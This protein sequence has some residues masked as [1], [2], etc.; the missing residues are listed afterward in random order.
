MAPKGKSRNEDLVQE[1]IL[2]AVVIADSFNV[3]FGPMTYKKPRTLLPLVNIPLI[4]YTFEALAASGVQEV[5]VFCCHLGDQVR[6]HV[7]QSKWLQGGSP[8]TVTTLMSD[9]CLSMG[10]ALR[11]IDAKSLIR[12]DFILITGDLVSNMDISQVVKEHKARTQGKDKSSVMT[13]VYK[14]ALPGHRTRSKEDDIFLVEEGG[15]ARLL[16]FQKSHDHRKIQIP[17]DIML[18]HDDIINHNDLMDC[19]ISVCS[20][21]VPTIFTDNFDYQTRDHFVKGILVSEEISGNKVH[22]SI[23]RDKYA[24]RVSNMHTYDA[25]SKDVINRWTYPLVP[26]LFGSTQ[27]ERIKYGRHNVYCSED[28]TLSRGCDLGQDV[29]VGSG[30]RIGSGSVISGCVIGKNCTIGENV[31]LRNSYLWDNVIVEDKCQIDTALLCSNV[32][33]LNNVIIEKWV[34]LAWEVVVG[35]NIT[36]PKHT[37]LISEPQRQLEDTDLS[38]EDDEVTTDGKI[39]NGEENKIQDAANYGDKSKAYLYTAN[40]DS[41][42]EEDGQLGD[43]TWGL[44]ASDSEDHL[45]YGIESDDS[46]EEQETDSEVDVKLDSDD[47]EEDMVDSSIG[48]NPKACMMER[49]AD[50]YQELLD[51]FNRA[52]NMKIS[53][54]NL[55][56]EIN[57]LKHAYSVPIEQVIHSLPSVLIELVTQERKTQVSAQPQVLAGIKKNFERFASLL[58]KYITNA[59]RQLNVINGIGDFVITHSDLRPNLPQLLNFLYDV[60]VLT[61]KA[62]FSWYESSHFTPGSNDALRHNFLKRLANRFITWLH[63]AEEESSDD[64]EDDE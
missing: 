11:E 19:H 55:I 28:V 37:Q 56:L 51:T 2:Q 54:D 34:I 21:I 42:N 27:W 43:V 29:V 31:T 57:S 53:D 1:D 3:R 58:C 33:V 35:P 6:E 50:F 36:V 14:V 24:A 44:S 16:Y 7:K 17:V 49:N 13:L 64:D 8:M 62:I 12:N 25:I 59:E 47:E 61:E 10:D 46:E 38:F 63:E 15:T 52:N 30:T 22:L 39:A 45:S 32:K 48:F 5:Y 9:S 20:P 23:I 26:D 41:D 4:D 60:D 40:V 18:E